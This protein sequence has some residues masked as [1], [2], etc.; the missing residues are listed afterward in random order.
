MVGLLVRRGNVVKGRSGERH[1][2]SGSAA[3]CIQDHPVGRADQTAM[4]IA[5][6]KLEAAQAD[7][8]EGNELAPETLVF[9][10][11]FIEAWNRPE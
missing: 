8:L 3:S 11:A 6:D 1:R 4:G 7:F 10:V 2:Q 9:G 5:D